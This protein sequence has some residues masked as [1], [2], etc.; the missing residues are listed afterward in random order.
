M[1]FNGLVVLGIV[2]SLAV[3]CTQKEPPVP[4]VAEPT[5][6]PI[7]SANPSSD[8]VS[9]TFVTGEK[10]T[11][12]IVS[13][14]TE[15]DKRYLELDEAFETGSGPD[16]FVL[17]HRESEPKSYQDAD[18]LNLGELQNTNGTQRYEI[19]AGTNPDEF[20][21]VVIWCRQFNATFGYAPLSQ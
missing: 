15:G 18:Y 9:G 1:K 11:Q 17:L 3:G 4:Q 6:T 12:G 16:V 13:V 10:T 21:S 8:T 20:G 19:P 14:V 5:P 7:A 2:A